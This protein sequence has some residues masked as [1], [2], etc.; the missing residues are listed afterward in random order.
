MIN[1]RAKEEVK[2]KE[3]NQS[4]SN[5]ENNDL[6]NLKCLVSVTNFPSRTE[7][8]D[9]INKFM[10]N[11]NDKK[12][13]IAENRGTGG[14]DITFKNPDQSYEFIKQLNLLKV[15]NPLY[16][17]IKT[18]LTIDVK[19]RHHPPTEKEKKQIQKHEQKEERD[20]KEI[21]NLINSIDVSK[22]HHTGKLK[23]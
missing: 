2:G 9:I 6:K 16:S 14:L 1:S 17:K 20:L 19:K 22:F 11:R 8:Y 3:N 18:T 15:N 7:L 4:N 21:E 10:E 13:Y 5:S 12:N 23:N